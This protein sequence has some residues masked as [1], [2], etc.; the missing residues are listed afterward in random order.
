M[1][2]KNTLRAT[3]RNLA[4]LSAVTVGAASLAVGVATPGQAAPAPA[5][6]GT[7]GTVIDANSVTMPKVAEQIGATTAHSQGIDGMG[8]DVA[9][10][11]TGVALVPGLASAGKVVDSID[12]S[13]DAVKPALRYRDLNGHGTHMAGLI[14]GDGGGGPL[15]K[16]VAPKARIINVK[17]G[18]GDGSVDV[19]QVIAALDWIVQ[20]KK[21]NG[22][23]IRVVSLSMNTD[24]KSSDAVVSPLSLAVE[25]AWRAGIVVVVSAGN[26]NQ[27]IAKLGNPAFNPNVIAVTGAQANAPG[28][29]MPFYIPWWASTGD[30]VRNPDVA[31]PGQS[32]AG[33]RVPGSY[34]DVNHSTARTFDGVTCQGL[35][36]GTGTSQAA[37]VTAGA[38][39]LLLQKNPALTPDQVK[40]ILKSTAT[41]IFAVDANKQGSGVI[42][43]TKAL[44]APVP[45]V[46]AP[47]YVATG[48]G[49]LE[50]AR[51][52]HHVGSG[53][54]MLSGENSAFKNAF[55]STTWAA[56]S[57]AGTAWTKVTYDSAGRFATGTWQG[58]AWSGAAWSGAAWS[59]AAWSGAAWSGAA[60]SGAAWSG[61]A[62]SGAAWSGAAW[63]GAA[64][65][66]ASWS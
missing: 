3:R 12:L 9:V 19:S 60:W 53:A 14:A 26:E 61:A 66:E 46:S 15:T 57:K 56:Q 27:T 48:T 28:G 5:K 37:A 4:L 13:F 33:L 11:D 50:A 65:S 29:Y 47:M 7:V 30:G 23:N 58:A 63:S 16:G 34:A 55:S 40:S 44:A 35:F 24:A 31:A 10:I 22:N 1:Q 45:T 18:A 41:N 42:N 39:A 20:N 21:S 52:A 36:R 62:W 2:R 32:V 64:W 59:G 17:V 6:C 49:S 8:V 38:V 25:N 43:V 54:N 51:G